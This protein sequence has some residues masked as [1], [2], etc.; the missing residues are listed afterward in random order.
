MIK[1]LVLVLFFLGSLPSFAQ[2][3]I[4]KSNGTI[5]NTENQKIIPDQVRE[6][7]ANNEKLLAEYNAGRSKK[8]AGNVLLIGGFGLIA[9]DLISGATSDGNTTVSGNG[10]SIQSDKNYPTV[11]TYIGVAAVV[12]A[13]PIKIGFS[14]KIRNVVSEYNNLEKLGYSDSNFKKLDLI[15]NS[16]GIGLRLTL[17]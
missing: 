14:K 8:T 10:Y 12:I 13:I 9:A 4:Y 7:L 15:T 17:N 11:L 1:Q 5:F 6:V 16:N 2:K 3:W